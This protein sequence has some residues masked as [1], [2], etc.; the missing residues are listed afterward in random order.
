[1]NLFFAIHLDVYELVGFKVGMT[2]HSIE[3]Y[4]LILILLTL[5]FNKVTGVQK[6]SKQICGN[7][8]TKF[9]SLWMTFVI[10]W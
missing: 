6:K 3:L 4:I 7:Y 8:L 10:L 2:S 1:M 9:Q 5:T